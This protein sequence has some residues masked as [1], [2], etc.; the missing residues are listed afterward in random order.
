MLYLRPISEQGL[1][2]KLLRKEADRTSEI[3]PR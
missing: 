2:E 1:V 3:V